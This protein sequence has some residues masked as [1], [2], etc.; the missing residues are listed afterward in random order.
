MNEKIV[1]PDYNH[2]ILNL[3]TSILKKYNVETKYN[4][5]KTI[6][7]ILKDKFQNVVLI[8]LDG[9]GEA[10]LKNVSPNGLFINNQKDIITSVYPTTTA[11]AMTTYYS[12]KPPTETGWISACLFFKEYGRNIKPLQEQDAYTHEKI[13]Q[14]NIKISDIIGYKTIYEQIEEASKDVKTYEIRPSNCAQ[15]FK[16]TVEADNIKE[17]C[18]KIQN[19]CEDGEKKFI[20]S[21]SSNPDTTIHATGCYSEETKEFILNAEKEI[22]ELAKNLIATNTL[23]IVSADH[24]HQDINENID[25]LN[26]EELQDCLLMPAMFEP[27]NTT[28]FVKPDKKDKFEEIFKKIFKDKYLLYKKEEL[29]KSGL[30]GEGQKHRKIDDF[31]GD[32]VAIAVSDS[33]VLLGTHVS[34][35]LGITDE[36]KATHAGLTSNEMEVP[37][38]VFNL[39]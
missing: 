11:A 16:R 30:F 2:S 9:M 3:I 20:L 14:N 4:S 23:L 37:L 17:M 27:R 35:A 13:N 8:I 22:G 28:F 34:R 38:I 29:L 15:K 24:G 1:M 21:Y 5:L 12:G 25:I 33:Q 39:K 31:I 18:S 6:D 10:I 32:Y 7:D 26:I 36:K 19:L